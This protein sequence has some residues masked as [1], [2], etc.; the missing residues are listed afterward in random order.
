MTTS[1]SSTTSNAQSQAIWAA[2]NGSKASSS[3]SSSSGTSSSSNDTSATG[4]QNQ[5]LKLLT[6]QLQNQDPLNPMDNA[7]V[8]SQLAQISTVQGI[9]Q[10]NTTLQS[11][12]G[13]TQ[14]AQTMQAAS[15][16]GH[17]VLV[18]GSAM[19]L[20]QGVGYAGV[21]LASAADSVT[22]TIKDS[23]GQVVRTMN[24]GS[25]D[26]GS[27]LFKWDGKTDNGSVAADGNYKFSVSA[28]QGGN[29]VTATALSVGSVNSVVKSGSGFTL[30]VGALGS[31]AFSDVREV[32]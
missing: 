31:F 17:N 4:I 27:N 3:S 2:L 32:L 5:F 29:N 20:Y 9:Q 14:D 21:D 8:T 24:V 11:M 19:T 6:T 15:L 1:T 30:D 10:L 18:P 13:N 16:V 26:A 7:Q 28:V 12:L 25:A 23:N 22:V